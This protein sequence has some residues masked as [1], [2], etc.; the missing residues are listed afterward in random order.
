MGP[1]Q[2]AHLPLQL[3]G[4]LAV[5][6]G[7]P[8]PG[9]AVDLGPLDPDAQRLGMDAQLVGD[10]ADRALD[11]LRDPAGPTAIRVARSRSPSGY[12]LGTLMT[13]TLP[14]VHC[15]HR[16]HGGT[17]SSPSRTGPT[18]SSGKIPKTGPACRSVVHVEAY[19]QESSAGAFPLV[20]SSS[21]RAVNKPLSVNGIRPRGATLSASQSEAFAKTVLDGL[22][23]PTLATTKR[24]GRDYDSHLPISDEKIW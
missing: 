4:P 5:L 17:Q 7:G 10:P 9:A 23:N 13:V 16:T 20:K 12:F 6:A 8:R 24:E 19:S 2:L 3:S 22:T 1:P 15:L 11:A 14:C 18:P 21:C